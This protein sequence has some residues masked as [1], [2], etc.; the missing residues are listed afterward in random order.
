MHTSDLLPLHPIVYMWENKRDTPMAVRIKNGKFNEKLDEITYGNPDGITYGNPDGI[1]VALYW[2]YRDPGY[3]LD[4][5]TG[6]REHVQQR[7]RILTYPIDQ[8][9]FRFPKSRT[10]MEYALERSK[11]INLQQKS[12]CEE[13]GRLPDYEFAYEAEGNAPRGFDDMHN[14]LQTVINFCSYLREENPKKP[15]QFIFCDT[16]FLH[17]WRSKFATGLSNFVNGKVDNFYN[18]NV[19]DLSCGTALIFHFRWHRSQEKPVRDEKRHRKY[20]VEKDKQY[21]KSQSIRTKEAHQNGELPGFTKQAR[22]ARAKKQK[23]NTADFYE[24]HRKAIAKFEKDGKLSYR[25]LARLLNASPDTLTSSGTAWS[26]ENL[27]QAVKRNN[28][29]SPATPPNPSN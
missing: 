11:T 24:P 23:Q 21:R 14:V 13:Y 4:Q 1:L 17:N 27:K 20:R 5:T 12:L 16:S 3:Y 25:Q 19:A 26:A 9:G 29:R 6:Q 2:T 22:Q 28:L 7:T 18:V 10:P 15:I 8:T